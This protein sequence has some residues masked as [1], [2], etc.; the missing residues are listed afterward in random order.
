MIALN[1]LSWVIITKSDPHEEHR[2]GGWVIR[3]SGYL[4]LL[5]SVCSQEIVLIMMS[6][7]FNATLNSMHP[8]HLTWC[9]GIAILIWLGGL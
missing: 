6:L 9:G 8:K 5:L 7:L 2:W 4:H 3:G 1:W